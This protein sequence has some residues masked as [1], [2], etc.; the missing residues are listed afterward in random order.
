MEGEQEKDKE[1]MPK[2]SHLGVGETKRLDQEGIYS[3]FSS[4]RHVLILKPGVQ[5]TGM[6]FII[7]YYY[8]L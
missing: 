7:I 1:K 6:F 4:I 3:G 8:T 5:C 2:R